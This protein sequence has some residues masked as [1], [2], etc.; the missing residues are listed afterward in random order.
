MPNGN[1][2]KK[3]GGKKKGQ[4]QRKPKQGN[5]NSMVRAPIAIS[6]RQKSVR[7]KL[8]TMPA[9]TTVSHREILAGSLANSAAFSV[10][11][12]IAVQPGISTY[13]HGS[14]L[15]NWLPNVAA[16]Y[17][18]YEFLKLKIHYFTS[19]ASTTS[20]MVV[21]SY[22]PNP[23]GALPTDFA[24]MRNSAKCETGAVR[25]NLV[26]DISDKVRGRK[27]LTRDSTVLAYPLYD[28]GRIY[29]A[30]MNGT[31]TSNVGYVEVE[32]T[33]RLSNPQ[34]GPKTSQ[35]QALIPKLPTLEWNATTFSSYSYNSA[36]DCLAIWG[37]LISTATPTGD[38]GYVML[39]VIPCPAINTT[40]FN[41]CKF[42]QPVASRTAI[43][44]L[45]TG[46]Y[47]VTVQAAFDFQDLKLFC[48]VPVKW[49]NGGSAVITYSQSVT[50][51][52]VVNKPVCH[53]GFTGVT[54]LD[55]DPGTDLGLV[56]TWDVDLLA[57]DYM[58]PAIGVR[59]YNSVSTTTANVINRPDLG[60]SYVKIQYLGPL[61]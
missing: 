32:Y 37:D 30:T 26:F 42:V 18:N 20:G 54:T 48:M 36:T 51:Q 61:T 5:N 29:I 3:T 7:P 38:S 8:Q 27:L 50:G 34:T 13:N 47:R 14:P 39:V 24:T 1:N 28:A 45:T 46:R 23:D 40:V 22:D 15:G 21:M 53:R 43:Y 16:Q 33:V 11:S 9:G 58:L 12:V 25:E 49:T 55:P 31:D 57:G 19:A 56:G 2:K 10:N 41:G 52:N 17:D 59:T 4:Q 44:A 6:N 60:P 35:G